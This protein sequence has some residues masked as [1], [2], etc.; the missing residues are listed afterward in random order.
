[1]MIILAL[2]VI[3]KEIIAW[4]MGL[5]LDWAQACLIYIL[6]LLYYRLRLIIQG[7]NFEII[8]GYY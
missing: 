1:M 3:P 4:D 2:D 5:G 6:S 8:V 7:S